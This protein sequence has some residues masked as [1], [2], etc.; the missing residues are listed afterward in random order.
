MRISKDQLRQI[1]KETL[2]RVLKEQDA[3]NP[4][5]SGNWG[6]TAG[7]DPAQMEQLYA[8]MSDSDFEPTQDPAL[9]NQKDKVALYN[10]AANYFENVVGDFDKEK[11]LRAHALDIE[12]STP[13][14]MASEQEFVYKHGVPH[15]KETGEWNIQGPG[16]DYMSEEPPVDRISV[17]PVEMDDERIADETIEMHQ[18][19]G[20][21]ET[22]ERWKKLIK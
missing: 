11:E 22:L 12:H 5:E 8:M 7:D 16:T 18:G 1:I 19:T 3:G 13:E 21:R 6:W 9:P 2:S 4:W 17:P 10:M 14:S 20:M 15:D